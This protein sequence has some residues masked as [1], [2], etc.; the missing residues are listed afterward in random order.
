MTHA[1]RLLASTGCGTAL[2]TPSLEL[3]TPTLGER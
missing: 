2:R 3:S 1:I